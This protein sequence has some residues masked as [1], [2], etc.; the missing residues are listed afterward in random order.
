MNGKEFN[1]AQRFA[2]EVCTEVTVK[3]IEQKK[4]KNEIVK[5]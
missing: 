3:Y 1:V 4:G 2:E 5:R